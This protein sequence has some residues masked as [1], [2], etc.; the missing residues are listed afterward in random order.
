MKIS[1]RMKVKTLKE[2]FRSEFGVGIR[3][4]RGA[5]FAD[6]EATIASIRA[7]GVPAGSASVEIRGNMKVGNAEKLLKEKFGIKVQVEDVSGKLADDGQTMG[8]LKKAAAGQ[9]QAGE[10]SGKPAEGKAEKQ[11]VDG[12]IAKESPSAKVNCVKR[13]ISIG[14]SDDI[15]FFGWDELDDEYLS[16]TGNSCLTLDA[17]Q[18]THDDAYDLKELFTPPS[19]VHVTSQLSEDRQKGYIFEYDRKE[20]DEL[21]EDEDG[22]RCRIEKVGDRHYRIVYSDDFL[23]EVTEEGCP[24]F[25]KLADTVVGG[26]CP[27]AFEA[28]E[29]FNNSL[30]KYLFLTCIATS[31]NRTSDDVD[32]MFLDWAYDIYEM[33]IRGTS[34]LGNLL[35]EKYQYENLK[36]VPISATSFEIT[37]DSGA[38]DEDAIRNGDGSI[39]VDAVGGC[40]EGHY[41]DYEHSEAHFFAKK[42]DCQF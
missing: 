21:E 41:F 29:P 6:D 3:V 23:W 8:S 34:D 42:R 38:I 22:W 4:Y 30:I 28:G 17:Y 19:F 33:G 10:P 40:M 18:F 16:Y 31:V 36:G 25:S 1:G 27:D 35:L 37:Y 24:A 11:A 12:G 13:S 32:S 9:A 14:C 26:L 2:S 39:N 15:D 20:S 5:R 7:E